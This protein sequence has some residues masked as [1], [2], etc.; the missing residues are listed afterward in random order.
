MLAS[1]SLNEIQQD[2]EKLER[3][4][5]AATKRGDKAAV[6]RLTRERSVLRMAEAGLAHQRRLMGCGRIA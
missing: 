4:L 2:R 5:A 6:S 1:Q 3:E